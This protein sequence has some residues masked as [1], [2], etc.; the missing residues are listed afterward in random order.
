MRRPVCCW[1]SGWSSPGRPE[2]SGSGAG[3]HLARVCGG[4]RRRARRR[5]RGARVVSRRAHVRR[6]SRS[7]S[8]AIPVC[9]CTSTS[10]SDRAPSSPSVSRR[11]GPSPVIVATTSGTAAAELL[12]AVVEASQSRM[13]LVL[14]TADRPP[15]VRGTG[16]NQTIVQ[17][18]LFGGYVRA[19]STSPSRRR[20]GRR[21]GGARLPAR[22]WRRWPPTR[23]ARST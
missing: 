17:P 6:R 1:R 2:R 18:E 21:H 23:R 22:R 10:T 20:R 4:A 9:G 16:A 7:P 13:P 15:R 19:S 5:R 12:P 11:R 3:G 8:R 14:L